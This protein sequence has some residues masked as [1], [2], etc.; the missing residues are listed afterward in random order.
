MHTSLIA[1]PR[2]FILSLAA[3]LPLA[4]Q[5]APDNV[6]LYGFIKVDIETV[7]A[8]GVRTQRLSNDLSVLG[9]RG[10]EDLGGGLQSFFQIEM[11]VSVDTGAGG[12]FTRNTGV[13][14]R[15]SF[16]QVL[17]GIWES[18]YRFV[19]V[20]AVD[21]FTAGIFASNAIIGNGFT[22]AANGIAPAS[23]DRRQKN[24]LQYTTPAY[25]GWNAR[26][27]VSAR[28]EG[29]AT[30]GNPGMA[31][32][33][34]TYEDETLYLAYG[35]ERHRDYFAAGTTDTGHKLGAAY[36]IGGTR[37]R[38]AWERLRYEPTAATHLSRD[39][40]QLAAT[41]SVGSHILRAS[42]TRA[43]QA[44]G[45]AAAGIGGIGK[46]GTDSGARQWT[47]GYGYV[48]SKRSEL[49]AAWTR[50]RN[51]KTASYNLSANPVAGLAAGQ[52]PSGAGF[53]ITHKF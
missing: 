9:W 51:G 46:P 42:L 7:Q 43:G 8:G 40:W 34:V 19:S 1:T 47:V 32:G 53:G 6:G 12:D 18:P 39:A 44:H 14:L 31:A 2:R 22:T 24:L 20:Y 30:A 27:A 35:M 29:S 23:F 17:L 25:G 26:V 48:L 49:W 36:S 38:A 5:A 45:N 10:S 28:E 37:L 15:G 4:A 13:G 33:L 11:P 16:G 52:D 21:P 50:T 3:A 41:H